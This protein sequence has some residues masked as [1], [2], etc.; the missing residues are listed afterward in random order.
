MS[1]A[2]KARALYKGEESLFVEIVEAHMMHGV[3][4]VTPAVFVCAR[5]VSRLAHRSLILDPWHRHRGSL[6]AWFVYVAV[7]RFAEFFR[8]VPFPLDFI[9]FSRH[10]RK[11]E[12]SD[13]PCELKFYP[14]WRM[15]KLAKSPSYEQARHP[16]SSA[17]PPHFLF[18]RDDPPQRSER[19]GSSGNSRQEAERLS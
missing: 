18:K 13:G 17:R 3:V 5:P 11:T 8:F 7:G 19:I 14:Y 16:G 10:G 15:E 12:G 2:E 1:P 9:G 4:F 6:D